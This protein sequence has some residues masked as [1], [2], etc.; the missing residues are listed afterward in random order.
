VHVDDVA[1]SL[2][3]LLDRGQ[4]AYN[5]TAP[6]PVTNRELSKALGRA[7]RR[8][9]VA[10]VPALALKL[11]YGEMGRIVTTGVRAVPKRLLEEGHSFAHAELD[12]A[13]R[14]VDA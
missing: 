2:L 12:E 4:G 5:V 14:A 10:P 7:L 8:P 3:F 6:R 13:L 9:A 1:R 11:L